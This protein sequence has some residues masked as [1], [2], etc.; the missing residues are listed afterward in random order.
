MP[1]RERKGSEPVRWTSRGGEIPFEGV[2]KLTRLGGGYL[3]FTLIVGFAALNTGNNS[4]YI[5]LSFMFGTLIFSGVASRE[6]LRGV[7]VELESVGES[8]AGSP[9]EGTL[10]LTNSS[11]LWSLRDVVILAPELERPA[12]VPALARRSSVDT[13]A[14]F[15]FRDRGYARIQRLEL[16]TRY[17]FGLFLKR[18]VVRT[19]AEVIVFPRL[20]GERDLTASVPELGELQ[21]HTRPGDGQEIYALREYV[22]GDSIR[23]IHWKKSAATGKTIIKQHAADASAAMHV[24]LDAFVPSSI[25]PER[26]EEIVSEAASAVR[27]AHATGSE[28]VLHIGDRE[29]R[30]TPETGLRPIFEALALVTPTRDPSDAPDYVEGAIVFSLRYEAA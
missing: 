16:Y 26:F 15:R 7:S 28:V 4:L 17:P 12:I 20:L 6:G 21:T 5:T 25:P 22:P 9:T 2:V 27:D 19:E 14:V 18:R 13:E 8:W 10:R 11:R 24:A 1:K 23:H 30:E 29:I 3:V